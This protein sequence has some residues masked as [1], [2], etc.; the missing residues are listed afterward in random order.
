[1]KIK[2]LS[3]EC[4]YPGESKDEIFVVVKANGDEKRYPDGFKSHWK[5]KIGTAEN[6]NLDI[7]PRGNTDFV[8]INF[9]EDDAGLVGK[10]SSG[11]GFGGLK[12]AINAVASTVQKNNVASLELRKNGDEIN[13]NAVADCKVVST[14]NNVSIIESTGANGR[15]NISIHVEN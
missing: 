5:F 6:L 12:T 4:V 7:S 11:F 15:Y 10:V 14:N 1:M 13:V 8:E 2:L 3:I 9:R